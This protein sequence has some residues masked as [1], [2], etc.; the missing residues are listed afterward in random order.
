[1]PPALS[2]VTFAASSVPSA[3]N[4]SGSSSP[5]PRSAPPVRRSVPFAAEGDEGVQEFRAGAQGVAVEVERDGL[6]RGQQQREAL[7][8]GKVALQP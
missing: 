8:E 4:I 7:A 2:M 5:L 6:I 1:M 3:T